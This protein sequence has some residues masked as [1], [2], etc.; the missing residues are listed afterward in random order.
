ME[1]EESENRQEQLPQIQEEMIVSEPEQN[2]RIEE[3]ETSISQAFE[4]SFFED[5][6]DPELT[7]MLDEDKKNKLLRQI[8]IMG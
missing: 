8:T 7:S 5:W 2:Q 6:R 1:F 3:H 4:S